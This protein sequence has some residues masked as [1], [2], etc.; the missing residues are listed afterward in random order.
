MAEKYVTDFTSG[1]VPKKMALF[2]I[3]LF[4]SNLFQAVYNMVDMIIVGQCVGKAGLSAVS[5][6]GD[7]LNLLTF[8][9][10][11]FSNAGQVIIAQHLG[12]GKK[13]KIGQI[14]VNLTIFL[15]SGAVILGTFTFFNRGNLLRLMN[16]PPEAWEHAFSYVTVCTLGLLFVYGYN[17][18]S[19]ILRGMG[20]SRHPFIFIATAAVINLVLDI[21]FIAKL[22]MGAFG[23]ALATV[24]GQGVSFLCGISFLLFNQ[25][26]LGIVINRKYIKLNKDILRNLLTLGCPMAIKS[27]AVMFS[28]LFVNS[29]I[30]SYGVIASSATAIYSKINV[31][32]NLFSNAINMSASSMIAQNIGAE[33]YDRVPKVLR[34]AMSI[35]LSVAVVLML[36]I[37]TMPRTIFGMFTPDPEVI[38]AA[39]LLIPMLCALFFGSACRAPSNGLIDGSGNY[40]LNFLVAI[41]DGIV[42]RIGF[43]VLF[44]L[45]LPLGWSGFLWGDVIA[46]FTPFVIGMI[47]YRT[48]RWKRN[49]VS[50]NGTSDTHKPA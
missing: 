10:M 16:T 3:P 6:G 48:G 44:G 5:V 33:R 42:N 38:E 37:L 21:I 9:A 50:H 2:A 17:V 30:N 24:I 25:K 14:I 49:Y 23:A 19:A 11:G 7:I 18:V 43:S 36:T 12:A 46:G 4:V 8:F 28:K 45:V 29:W 31:I 39:M 27:A 26:K 1:S 35:T 22:D 34:T 47:Y 13:E 41:L 15:F 32:S 20:D 40:K